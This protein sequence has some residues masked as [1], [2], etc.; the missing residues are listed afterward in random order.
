VQRHR[1]ASRRGAIRKCRRWRRRGDSNSEGQRITSDLGWGQGLPCI[2]NRVI[3]RSILSRAEAK[4]GDA[5]REGAEDAGGK[6]FQMC[7]AKNRGSTPE[8]KQVWREG[9]RP[10]EWAEPG[11]RCGGPQPVKPC[12]QGRAFVLAPSGTGVRVCRRVRLGLIGARALLVS[13]GT[14]AG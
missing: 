13:P 11:D 7:L 12:S 6:F 14:R 5:L 3:G 10:Q 4:D 1:K 2:D 8:Q 9:T